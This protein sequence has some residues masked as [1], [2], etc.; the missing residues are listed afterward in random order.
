MGSRVRE[1]ALFMVSGLLRDRALDLVD[2]LSHQHD[3]AW[4]TERAMRSMLERSGKKPGERSVGRVLRQ[5]ARD[6]TIRRVR[7]KPGGRLPNGQYT[8]HGTTTNV[9]I[10]RQERR[11][12]GRKR[13][14]ER[15]RAERAAKRPPAAPKDRGDRPTAQREEQVSFAQWSAQGNMSP[16]Q[17][18]LLGLAFSRRGTGPPRPDE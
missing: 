14:R 2:A 7:V 1:R 13:A 8:R 3:A 17:A 9:R 4:A 18:E 5:A 6:G 12:E 16:E 15:R 10:S 11:A